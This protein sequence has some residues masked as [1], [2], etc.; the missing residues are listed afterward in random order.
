MTRETLKRNMWH[1]FLRIAMRVAGN[2]LDVEAQDLISSAYLLRMRHAENRRCKLRSEERRALA[3]FRIEMPVSIRAAG[4][5][6]MLQART[7]D[8]SATGV[9]F[10]T[11]LKLIEGTNIDFIMTLPPE[12]THS[13]GI[14]IACSAKIVRV[15]REMDTNLTGIAAAIESFDFLAA[16]A[17]AGPDGSCSRE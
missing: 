17:S 6:S 4:T 16:A 10:Y 14:Q 8:V 11:S 2:T 7:R 9:F 15:Q 12:L 1:H 13:M 3:R 5:I